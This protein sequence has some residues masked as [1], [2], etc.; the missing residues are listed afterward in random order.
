MKKH[1]VMK[2]DAALSLVCG[3]LMAMLVPMKVWAV[4]TVTV[5]GSV[6][7]GTTN[8][9]LKLST[10]EGNMEIKIDSGTDA[11]ACKVLLPGRQVSVSV[12]HSTD[13]YLHATKITSGTQTESYTLDSSSNATIT[14]TISEK[15][16]EDVLCVN[17]K[18]GEMQIK[19][20]PST[21]MSGCSVLVVNRMYTITC[22][23]GSDAYMHATAIVDAVSDT[24]SSVENGIQT[25]TTSLTPSPASVVTASTS[26]VTGKVDQKT[27]EGLLYL[28]T[29]DGE[30]QVIIDSNTDTRN[31]MFMM[32]GRE[33]T[34]TVYRGSD[35]YMHAAVITGAKDNVVPASVDSSSTSTVSGSVND[36]SN[37][38]MLYL[39]TKWG[40]MELKLDTVKSMTGY[41]ILTED[42]KVTVTCARGADA[43]MHV[44][45]L[46]G[47]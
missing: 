31:G 7:S 2:L 26:T 22:A 40:E 20:D 14:G 23:R 11:S 25:A 39:Q 3:I 16:Q 6:M 36:R 42:R 28:S 47:N 32:P 15:S 34:V 38:N 21:N 43:Y 10:Q 13:G 8:D 18:Q 5:Q 45:E 33:I 37:E 46:V 27:E 1:R 35:A 30:M 9:L 29:A 12:S 24:N 44:V 19:L 41:K 4:E 17:T